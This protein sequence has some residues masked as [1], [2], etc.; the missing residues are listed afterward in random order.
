MALQVAT[1]ATTAFPMS[2]A[3]VTLAELKERVLAFAEEREWLQFHS[4]KNL[5]M[6]IAAESAELM[7]HF[8]WADS[9]DSRDVIHGEK[10]KQILEELAD[11]MIYSIEFANVAG[12]DL[13]SVIEAKMRRNAEKYPVE[14]ARG[15]AT[16]YNEL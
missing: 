2:D 7:E 10:R 8:L 13:A 11:I 12:I 4:P 15:R 9:E 14:K 16:K 1:L 5:S 3:D 6:A